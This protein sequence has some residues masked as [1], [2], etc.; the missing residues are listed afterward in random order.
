ML[1]IPVL[2]HVY[3][4]PAAQTSGLTLQHD[5]LKACPKPPFLFCPSFIQK[6]EIGEI[7]QRCP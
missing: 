1:D 2:T 4:C 5:V 6:H 3:I 7:E